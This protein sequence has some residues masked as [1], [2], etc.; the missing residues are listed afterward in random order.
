LVVIGGTGG[1]GRAIA[2]Q[3]L[4]RGAEV[5][6]VGRTFR[7]QKS[8]RLT[9]VAADLSSMRESVRL[10]LELP[11]ESFD[12]ALFT[13]G[14][15]ASRKAREETSEHVERD[16]AVSYLSRLAIL[17]GLSPRLGA[18]RPDGAARPRVFVMG[19]PGYRIL[20]D[21]DDLNSEQTYQPMVAHAATVAGN[22][23]LVLGAKDRFP[24]PAFFGL[25]PGLISTEIRSNYLGDGSVALRLLETAVGVMAQSPETY[26]KKIVPILF[27]PELEG[28]TGVLFGSTNR[29]GVLRGGDQPIL[30]TRDFDDAYI[31]RFL[32]ASE[33]LLRRALNE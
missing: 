10:G 32:S 7:D 12:V 8:P 26:A 1:L 6:V 27:A 19:S 11:A 16:V 31:D 22:E 20:G 30:P 18:G 17:Q 33:V 21:L 2:Q 4:A 15:I 28:R 13:A 3:A 5:T 14:I 23:I 9:F 29:L 24:G 25:G